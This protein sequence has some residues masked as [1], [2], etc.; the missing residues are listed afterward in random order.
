MSHKQKTATTEALNSV[1]LKPTMWYYMAFVNPK[2]MQSIVRFFIVI[3]P[4][5]KFWDT[6]LKTT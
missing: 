6:E 1:R 2:M 4:S 3:F 5:P